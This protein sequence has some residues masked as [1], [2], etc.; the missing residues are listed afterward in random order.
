MLYHKR[1][2]L[3]TQNNGSTP[4]QTRVNSFLHTQAPLGMRREHHS[5]E[6]LIENK[7]YSSLSQECEVLLD[8]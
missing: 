5:L 3:Y 6:K 8:G 1:A 4:Q 2:S 7:I